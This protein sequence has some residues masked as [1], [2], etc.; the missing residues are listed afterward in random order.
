MEK[1][2]PEIW[3]KSK[4]AIELLGITKPSF[5]ANR[6]KNKYTCRE[7]IGNGGKQFEILLSSLTPEAQAKYYSSAVKENRE[8]VNT[9]MAGTFSDITEEEKNDIAR[10]AYEAAPEYNRKKFD[11]YINI[12][13]ASKGLKGAQ[14]KSFIEKW[15]EL[16]PDMKT[17]YRR[18]LDA[19]K[20]VDEN[21]TVALLGEYGKS[22]GAT[23]VDEYYYQF[24]EKMYLTESKVPAHA[25]WVAALG[26]AQ[27]IDNS[28]TADDF[29]SAI[30]FLRLLKSRVPEQS[31]YY[32]RYGRDAWNKKYANYVDRDY[33][34]IL[35]GECW[36][37]D[38]RQIDQAVVNE[39][40]QR[41]DYEDISHWFGSNL[42]AFMNDRKSSYPVYPWLTVWRDFRT[43]K[44][45]GW[46]IHIAEPNTDHVMH[47]FNIAAQRY[48]IPKAIIIDNGKDYR[49]KDFAGGRIKNFKLKVAEKTTRSLCAQL[50][51]RVHFSAPYNAQAKPIERDFLIYKN[52]LDKIMPGYRGGNVT[53][54]PKDKLLNEIKNGMIVKLCDYIPVMDY[55]V[56]QILNEYTAEGKVLKGRSRNQAWMEGLQHA[57]DNNF[58]YPLR[59]VSADD[60]KLFMMR[61]SA[62]QPIMRNGLSLSQKYN[63][64]YYSEWMEGMKGRYVYMRRDNNRYQEAWVFD[65]TTDEYLGKALLNPW[66]ASALADNDISKKQLSNVLLMKKTTSKMAKSMGESDISLSP[67][68]MLEK[69]ARGIKVL[70]GENPDDVKKEK[71]PSTKKAKVYVFS[72]I[73]EQNMQEKMRRA[74]G[75]DYDLGDDIPSPED[76]ERESFL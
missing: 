71:L 76:D 15:N 33:K 21:G 72:K 61:T 75:G 55:F 24:F 64:Y 39:I 50:G 36:V 63:L 17:S 69:H 59:K 14:L 32:Q 28:I 51:I 42:N 2:K 11:K 13:E 58:D 30:T 74:Q 4:K 68:E 1:S 37:S 20:Q 70:N 9:V 52:W 31:I 43:G 26:Y 41:G 8:T 53:E 47:A 7:F 22:K 54:R 34:D 73:S 57:E 18:V 62:E 48:G 23:K 65:S 35:P 60:L 16:N 46:F 3:I 19:R 44:W 67:E 5:H 27:Q 25:C 10:A 12:L 49:A 56:N 38:H 45:L 29:P 6:K 66:R 40:K